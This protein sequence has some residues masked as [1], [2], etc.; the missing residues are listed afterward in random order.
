MNTMQGFVLVAKPAGISSTQCVSRVKR[1]VGRTVKVGHAGTLDT[2][3]TGLMIIG[4]SRSAT[5]L[6]DT[7]LTLDKHYRATGKLGEL[8]DTFDPTGVVLKLEP[9]LRLSG[10]SDSASYGGQATLITHEHIR[11]ALASFGATYEQIP[12]IFSALKYQG[13]RISTLARKGLSMEELAAVA[14]DKKRT[15]QLYNISLYTHN[16]PFFTIDAHVSHGTYIRSLVHDIGV[17][18][19]SCATTYVLERMQIGPFKLAHAVTLSDLIAGGS[20]LP[21]LISVAEMEELVR[22]YKSS[23]STTC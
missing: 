15:V 1:L 20:V 9:S 2:F 18:L 13:E 23:L 5:R 4:I 7:F 21:H 16:A 14:V 12:P 3:A 8:T 17:R 10:S 11:N 6:M 22:R 19:G